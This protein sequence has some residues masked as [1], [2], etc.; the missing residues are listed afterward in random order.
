MIKLVSQ[1]WKILSRNFIHLFIFLVCYHVGMMVIIYNL[2]SGSINFALSKAGYSYV[3]AE[4][5]T[6]FVCRPI[7]ILLIILNLMIIYI[8]YGLEIICLMEN[9]KAVNG[10]IKLKAYEIFAFG[11]IKAGEIKKTHTVKSFFAGLMSL[12]FIYFPFI[13]QVILEIKLFNYMIQHLY[14]NINPEWILYLIVI[15]ILALGIISSFAMPLILINRESFKESL[16]TAFKALKG[17]KAIYWLYLIIWNIFVGAVSLFF[18]FAI[19]AIATIIIMSMHDDDFAYSILLN[20]CNYNKFFNAILCAILCIAGNIAFIYSICKKEQMFTNINGL[21]ASN[22]AMPALEN[23]FKKNILIFSIFIVLI[24]VCTTYNMWDKETQ[25]AQD[26]LVVTQITAH[27]GGAYYAPE[28]TISAINTAIKMRADYVEIDVQLTKDGE[29]VLMHDSN[30]KRTAGINKEIWNVEYDEIKN[31]DVGS[32]FNIEFSGERIP[33]LQEVMDFT[34]GKIDLNIEIK[35][36]GHNEDIVEKVVN[37]IEENGAV[38]Q[39]VITSMNYGMLTKVKKLNPEIRTGYILK[40]AYGNFA[41]R[42]NADFFSI[43]HT[44]VT[45]K[46]ISQAHNCGKEVMAWTVNSI[47]AIERMKR[48]KVDNIITDRPALVREMLSDDN[49]IRGFINVFKYVIQ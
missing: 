36:N 34:K 37:I 31:L 11:I 42:I 5:F 33:T 9:F 24:E 4:N 21:N 41:N 12:P 29:I 43:K 45:S 47:N 18:Y 10:N 46:V 1:A 22:E 28:N 6:G 44:Y 17:K 20:I 38:H 27:R 32:S 14:E 2:A 7:S 8:L 3:T 23:S 25:I 39:C 48:L 40:M 13:S 26:L 15:F 16:V 19:A 35:D 30:L 49:A